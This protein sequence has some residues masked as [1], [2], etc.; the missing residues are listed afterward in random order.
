MPIPATTVE[1]VWIEMNSRRED[2][3]GSLR[4]QLA[5][6]PVSAE[7]P[8]ARFLGCVDICGASFHVDAVQ[9]EMDGH[10]NQF[11]KATDPVLKEMLDAYELLNQCPPTTVKIQDRDY[12]IFIYP[13]GAW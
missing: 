10:E 4:V 9:I 7:F 8:L 5:C 3:G 1:N 2:G 12:A 13:F 6:T 11:L